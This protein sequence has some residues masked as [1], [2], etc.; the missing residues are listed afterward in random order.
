MRRRYRKNLRLTKKSPNSFKLYHN[1]LKRVS[2]NQSSPLSIIYLTKKS[3]SIPSNRIDPFTRNIACNLQ[4][5][6]KLEKNSKWVVALKFTMIMR[7]S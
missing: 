3:Y 2:P 7:K 4:T 5:T 6:Y 1:W